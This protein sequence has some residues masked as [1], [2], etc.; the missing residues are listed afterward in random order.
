V[1]E[2]I[3]VVVTTPATTGLV[4]VATIATAK[5]L[6]AVASVRVV[7]MSLAR[8]GT[9]SIS[10]GARLGTMKATLLEMAGIATIAETW[11]TRLR[12]RKPSLRRAVVGC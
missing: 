6:I 2:G 9:H 4:V 5:S 11:L 1:R 10:A 7:V 3:L 8:A 12:W